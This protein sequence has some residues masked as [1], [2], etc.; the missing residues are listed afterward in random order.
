MAKWQMANSGH[1]RSGVEWPNIDLIASLGR[2]NRNPWER[3]GLKRRLFYKNRVTFFFEGI[4]VEMVPEANMCQSMAVA[5]Q[6]CHGM[7]ADLAEF[8]FGS[9]FSFAAGRNRQEKNH[10]R[11]RKG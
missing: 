9:F 3:L 4:V 11:A 7:R 1:V 10:G 5:E 6:G 8:F 2:V